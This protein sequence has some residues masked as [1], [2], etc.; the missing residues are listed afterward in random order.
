MKTKKELEE[1]PEV[2]V[3]RYAEGK[4]YVQ[5]EIKIF[6]SFSDLFHKNRLIWFYR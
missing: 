6:I 2:T 4:Q 5:I 3:N 1:M